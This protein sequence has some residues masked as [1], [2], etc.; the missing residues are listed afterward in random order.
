MPTGH[1]PEVGSHEHQKKILV[2]A[3]PERTRQDR[4]GAPATAL[5]RPPLLP[6]PSGIEK[7]RH[8]A[9]PSL[10]SIDKSHVEA[11]TGEGVTAMSADTTEASG[12]SA[13]ER[14]AMK[15]R[16]AEL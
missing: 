9:G 13:E 1:R 8:V 12:F 7:L 3:V 15:Q 10:T 4:H 11:Q 6:T 14:A 5:R 16:A 2:G